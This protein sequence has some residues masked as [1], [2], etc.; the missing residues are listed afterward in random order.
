MRWFVILSP[1]RGMCY[2]ILIYEN[3]QIVHTSVSELGSL[4]GCWSVAA[5][6]AT[7]NATFDCSSI[8]RLHLRVVWISQSMI[9][10]TL[11]REYWIYLGTEMRQI[12]LEL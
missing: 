12:E 3:Y 7:L 6:H 2:S 4:R 11:S 5:L 8:N 1:E 9:T 10:I